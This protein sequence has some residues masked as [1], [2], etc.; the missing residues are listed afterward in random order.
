MAIML[1][2]HP[3]PEIGYYEINVHRS[4]NIEIVAEQARK[5]VNRWIHDQVSYMMRAETPTFTVGERIVWRVPVV[6]TAPHVGRVGVV[7]NVD[8]DVRSGA[9]YNHRKDEMLKKAVALAEKMP[10]YQ[11]RQTVPQ[12][13]I[14][15]HIPPAQNADTFTKQPALH[16][17]R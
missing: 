2:Q 17:I 4:V 9:L 12:E 15:K 13:F 6:L 7:G 5:L 8:V 10:P 16:R 11:P 3:S 14:P 1:E